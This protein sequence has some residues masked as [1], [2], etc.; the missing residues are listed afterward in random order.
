MPADAIEPE[1][2]GYHHPATEQELAALVRY[3]DHR[4]LQVRVRGAA[5]SVARALYTD[6]LA[7]AENR[8][9]RQ[10]P[11]AGPH[12]N[13]MLDR[14]R[15]WRV[16]DEASRLVE[17]DAGIHLG[18]DPSDPAGASPAARGLLIQLWE[19]KGW[20]LAALGGIT[21]QTVS[22]FLSTGS[23]GG[24]LSFS[25]SQ[26]LYGVR[27]IDGRGDVHEIT[28]DGPG[29]HL[30]PAMAPA[31]GLLG[32]VS[33]VIL[34]CDPA[35]N[36]AGQERVTTYDD[37]PV[38]VFGQGTGGLTLEA[39]LKSRDYAR[40][41]W[42]PQ[43]GGERLETW[44]A[45]RIPADPT[46]KPRPY[47][48]FGKNPLLAQFAAGLFFSITANLR[49]LDAARHERRPACQRMGRAARE[50][51]GILG[52]PAEAVVAGLAR[53]L[54]AVLTFALAPFAGAL[55]RGLPKLFPRVL[56]DLRAAGRGQAADV[57]GLRVARAADGL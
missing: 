42:W 6:P 2:D 21:H 5:H 33:V 23:A 25:A 17:A 30:F 53:A 47:R 31:M 41:E 32:I 27:V 3:A 36:I 40:V 54:V 37:C 22:G 51:L 14:V 29:A 39:W 8:V 45:R 12:L 48:Q 26:N 20:T 9:G 13:V 28:R 56:G 34:E 24:S 1:D 4:G 55:G 46:F 38:D 11:P 16:R 57:R 35:F 7:D 44:E 15:C 18:V 52:R 43:R 49:D 10:Q 19:E 50:R